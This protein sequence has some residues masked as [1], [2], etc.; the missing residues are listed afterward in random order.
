MNIVFLNRVA[1]EAP[2]PEEGPQFTEE[3]VDFTLTPE[4]K[5]EEAE[6]EMVIKGTSGDC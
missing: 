2:K 5:P 4:Q 3:S 1:E 6:A